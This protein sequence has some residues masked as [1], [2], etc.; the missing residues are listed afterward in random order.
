MLAGRRVAN[1]QKLTHA[2]DVVIR[3]FSFRASGRVRAAAVSLMA[4]AARCPKTQAFLFTRYD[5]GTLKPVKSAMKDYARLLHIQSWDVDINS[6][7]YYLETGIV[8]GDG[9][10]QSGVF[11]ADNPRR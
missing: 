3:I 5:E 1:L 10:V 2:M 11:N 8:L 7:D 6:E 9:G 4:W